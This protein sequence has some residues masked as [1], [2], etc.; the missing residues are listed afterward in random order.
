MT[1]D[2]P[3]NAAEFQTLK[4]RLEELA[5]QARRVDVDRLLS[6]IEDLQQGGPLFRSRDV[7]WER[8]QRLAAAAKAFKGHAAFYL[9]HEERTAQQS[10][11]TPRRGSKA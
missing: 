4:G 8:L 10:S 3:Y 2:Q 9:E 5:A 7:P 1:D 11:N 6:L